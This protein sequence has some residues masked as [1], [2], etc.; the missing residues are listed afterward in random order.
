MMLDEM[1]LYRGLPAR[2]GCTNETNPNRAFEKLVTRL[3]MESVAF[4]NLQVIPQLTK[5]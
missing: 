4:S 2:F 3:V 5:K 1:E